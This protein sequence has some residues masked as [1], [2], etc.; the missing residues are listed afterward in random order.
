V[1]GIKPET[2]KHIWWGARA[3][4]KRNTNERTSRKEPHTIELLWDRQQM[5]GGTDEE[6]KKFSEWV[7]KKGLPALRKKLAEAYLTPSDDKEIKIELGGYVIVANPRR[8]FGYLYIGI[9]PS[10]DAENQTSMDCPSCGSTRGRR[11]SGE[12]ID[13]GGAEQSKEDSHGH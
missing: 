2:P 6:R 5:E 10:K 1:F 9:Y 3:I 12:C 7:N 13:C 8:S 4:Y 11:P